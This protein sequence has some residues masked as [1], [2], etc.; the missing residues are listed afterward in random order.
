MKS[1]ATIAAVT[2]PVGECLQVGIEDTPV[3]DHP[4]PLR[5][6]HDIGTTYKYP[7]LLTYLQCQLR[8]LLTRAAVVKRTWTNFCKCTFSVSGPHLAGTLFLHQFVT[9]TVIQ[10][11]TSSEVTTVLLCFYWITFYCYI[12]CHSASLS[13]TDYCNAWLAV[14]V[15][16][17]TITLISI[18]I[19][20]CLHFV[21][22]KTADFR[23]W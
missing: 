11:Q 15:W 21:L 23:W 2:G 8:S 18:I 17:G 4:T 22:F 12:F 3:F 14:F 1:S 20:K 13:C 16:L 19:I 10:L 6:L 7:E 5:R 9:S